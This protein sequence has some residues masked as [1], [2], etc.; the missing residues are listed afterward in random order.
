MRT[1]TTTTTATTTTTTATTTTTTA[2]TEL[3]D[4]YGDD[5]MRVCS[6]ECDVTDTNRVLELGGE[7]GKSGGGGDGDGGVGGGGGRL[8]E[9]YLDDI[10]LLLN[11]AGE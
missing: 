7:G 1:T 6:V 9:E 5:G 3:M 10:T 8:P 11:N 4:L 2:T